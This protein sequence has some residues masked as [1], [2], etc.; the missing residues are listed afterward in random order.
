MRWNGKFNKADRVKPSAAGMRRL[1][2]K[3]NHRGVVTGFSHHPDCYGIRWDHLK[4]SRT[5]HQ[6]F[7]EH[8]ILAPPLLNASQDE[9]AA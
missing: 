2:L 8:D 3:D 5:L 4:T 1:S 9:S 7:I 6:D